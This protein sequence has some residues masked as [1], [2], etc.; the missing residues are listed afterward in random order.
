MLVGTSGCMHWYEFSQIIC[1]HCLFQATGKRV[2][3]RCQEDS[4]PS[5]RKC[6]FCPLASRQCFTQVFSRAL[7]FGPP[8]SFVPEIANFLNHL[9]EVAMSKLGRPHMWETHAPTHTF[10]GAIHI[11]HP[12]G[13]NHLADVVR[14]KP[15]RPTCMRKCHISPLFVPFC[16]PYRKG[17]NS[18][19][20]IH[21]LTPCNILILS[22]T[23][24][25]STM[26]FWLGPLDPL[27]PT[28]LKPFFYGGGGGLNNVKR[29]EPP[30]GGG[31]KS[32]IFSFFSISSGKGIFGSQ[33]HWFG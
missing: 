27:P 3:K 31:Q 30:L 1:V 25:M 28:H 16:I 6:C 12:K 26:S 23:S 7:K 9:A 33:V 11:P 21:G 17:L 13:L 20:Q 15:C 19:F 32:R 29:I 22:N 14:S 4:C 8:S 18:W 2:F 24:I 10:S 5:P